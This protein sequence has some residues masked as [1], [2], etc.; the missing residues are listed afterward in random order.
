MHLGPTCTNINSYQQEMEM[1]FEFSESIILKVY[2]T[3]PMV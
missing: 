2:K 1:N 3:D